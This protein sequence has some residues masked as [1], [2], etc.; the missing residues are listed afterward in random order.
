LN[1]DDTV[2]T[3]TPTIGNVPPAT[4]GI[5]VTERHKAFFLR[6][7]K[8]ELHCHLLGTVRQKTFEALL[9]KH[10]APLS[11][12]DVAGFYRRDGKPIGVLRVLRALES[13]LLL[14]PDDFRRLTYE[15]LEDA[16][17]ESVRHAEF[18]WNPTVTIRDIGLSY[19]EVQAAIVRGMQ[20][21]RAD[22]DIGSLL[23]PAID[24]EA[25][26]ADANEMVRLMI[27]NPHE[28]VAGIGIDYRENERPPELFR[29]AYRMAKA[30]GLRLTAH[31]GEFGTP[32]ENVATVVEDLQVDRVDHG[33]T[34]IDNPSLVQRCI[35]LG[36]VF[37]IVPTNSYYLRTLDG[38]RWA[39]EHPIRRMIES[40]LKV[41]PNTD[42][43]TLHKVT[44]AG[45]WE[46]LFSHFGYSPANLRTMLLN[47]IDG[48]WAE[49]GLKRT[50]RS[51]W[52]AE[53]DALAAAA[54]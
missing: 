26:P 25:S 48:S 2:T 24:R 51:Q 3:V 1:R 12:E 7:P 13:H 17:R 29:E 20:D 21:A 40:G 41:H 8:V 19:A 5:T 47:G 53:F 46:L 6:I 52:A 43:P 33:Y 50:W 11:R 38:E 31:A 18:F 49:E 14:E 16:A 44:P 15:Y 45:A 28:A 34:V 54:F 10:R 36:L 22:F 37:T 32:W 27:A 9:D 39:L 35:D 42:D 30:A 23:I 4:T